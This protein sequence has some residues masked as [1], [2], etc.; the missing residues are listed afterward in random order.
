MIR[1]RLPAVLLDADGEM[2]LPR[3]TLTWDPTRPGDVA[4][5]AKTVVWLFSV[6]LLADGLNRPVEHNYV[7]VCRTPG[8]PYVEIVLDGSNR[9]AAVQVHADDLTAFVHAVQKAAQT[10]EAAS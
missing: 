4:L 5:H 9:Q 10:S 6:H 1:H 2:P 3:V 7:F 8:G